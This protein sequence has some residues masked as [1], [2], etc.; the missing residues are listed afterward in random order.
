MKT[1]RQLK[2]TPITDASLAKAGFFILD[3]EFKLMDLTIIKYSDGF[4][5][6]IEKL[7]NM[8]QVSKLVYGY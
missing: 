6:G 3:N 5:H 2:R 4:Y 8:F 1:N 7:D